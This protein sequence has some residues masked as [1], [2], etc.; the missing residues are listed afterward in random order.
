MVNRACI[1]ENEWEV[2]IM[3][4]KFYLSMVIVLTLFV[5]GPRE[6]KNILIAGEEDSI[7]WNNYEIEDI[8]L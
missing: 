3:F 7:K 6:Q 8:L 4:E 1:L 5:I 2:E